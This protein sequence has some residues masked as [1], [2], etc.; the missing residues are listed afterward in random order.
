MFPDGTRARKDLWLSCCT[1]HDRAYWL[2]GVRKE[3]SAADRALRDCVT[4][5]GKP[6]TA[7]LMWVGVRLGGTPYLPVGSRWGYGW[8]YGRGYAA[9]TDVEKEA[10]APADF[11]G[12]AQTP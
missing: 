6:K 7:K 1:E 12:P 4:R 8:R 10:A 11:K 2:G 5:T 3:R 9:V